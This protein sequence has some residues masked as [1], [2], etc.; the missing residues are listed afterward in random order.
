MSEILMGVFGI[1]TKSSIFMLSCL[2]EGGKNCN[3]PPR[4]E[5]GDIITLSEKR[6]RSGSSVE[7]RCQRFYAMEGQKI[8]FCNNGTWTKVPICLDPCRIPTAELERQKIEV[9]DGMDASENIFVQHGHSIELIC[10]T[11]YVL[12]ADSSQSAS[13]IHCDGTTPVIPKC[14]EIICN[15]PRI[16]N[17]SFRPKRNIY[18]V[19]D[20]IQ[21]QCYSGF[22]FEPDNRGQVVEC[23]KNGWSPPS[24]CVLVNPLIVCEEPDDIAFG[25]IVTME[26]AKYLEN[27]RVQYRCYPGYV[28]EGLEWIQCKGQQWTPRPPKCLAPCSITR[29]QLVT[30]NLFVFGSQRKSRFIQSNHSL[31]FQCSEGYVL[32][33]PSVRKCVDGYMD[34]PLCISERGKNCSDPPRIENGDIT[35]LSEKQY[36]SGSSV[37]FRCQRY[38]TIEGQNRSFCDNGTWT[39]VPI[40]L[41]PCMIPRAELE[42]QKIEVKGGMDASENIFVP[43]GHSIELTCRTGYV[44]AADSSQLACDGTPPVIPKCKEI[45]CSSPRILKGSFRPQRNIYNDGDLIRI[46]CDNGFTLEQDNGGQVAEC[47]RNGWLPSPKC[48]QVE[49]TCKVSLLHGSFVPEQQSIQINDKA[50]YICQDGYTTSKGETEVETQCLTEGWSPEPE[51]IR[52]CLKP[53][54]DNFIF[55]TTKPVFLPGDVLHYECKEEFEITKNSIS[56]TVVCTEEGW[57]PTPPRCVAFVCQAP[58]LENGA[59]DPRENVFQ[60]KMV[61]RFNCDTGFTRVGSESAQCYHFG[62][63][64]QPPV[65]KGIASVCHAPFL[66]NGAIN[67]REDVFQHKMVVRFNCDRGFIRVGSESAQCYHFGWSPQP[68]VC[69]E[70]VKSCQASPRISHGMVTDERK[71]VHQHGDLLEVQCDISFALRGSKT[72]ECVDGEWAPLPSC[73]EEVKTCGPPRKITRGIPVDAMS[74]I[75]RHGETVAYQCQQPSV[76]IGTNPAKCLHGQWELPSCLETCPPPP[77]L[78]NAI[79]IAEMRI[80]RSEEEI[81]FKCQGNFLLRGPPKIK[82]EDGKWQTPPRCLA[83][84]EPEDIDFGEIVTTEKAKYLE[85]ERVQYRCNPA[86]VLEGPEWIQCKGQKWTPHPPK[87]LAPCSITRQQ[88]ATKNLFVFGSQ[89]KALLIQSNHSR[90]FQCN[91]GYVLVAPSVRM[92]VDGYMELPL[93]ISERGRNCSG[94]PRIENGDITTLSEKR[95]RSGSS[96]EFR[97]QKDYAMEDQNRSFCDNGTWTKVPICLD[98]C[99]IPRAELESQMIELKDGIDVPENTFVQRG[100]SI[101]LTCRTGYVLAVDSSQSASIIHCDGT[102]PVIPKCKEIT[103]NSPRISNGSFL[104]QRT[105]YHD[106]DLIRIR[107]ESGFTFKPDNGE[108]VVECTKNGWSPPPK[109][110]S[111]G[112][113][114][115]AMA[116]YHAVACLKPGHVSGWPVHTCVRA[117]QVA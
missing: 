24:K 59:I 90:Q 19:G 73:I 64:P 31:Q 43:R 106:G 84:E 30:K 51:C 32:V 68:P 12:A 102:T 39:K 82:C 45:T 44:L 37:E 115:P 66:E 86:Y 80:Y 26:K 69:K 100:H 105:I 94:P 61:V 57:E 96:V 71:A 91:E 3:G 22:T 5:N 8:S 54:A 85:N 15:S 111:R 25:E 38:Y 103:C 78:P 83:C 4:I 11:G 112:S 74:S 95:Y 36:R 50:K 62:W 77:Q 104:P 58:F 7:F 52:T 49:R 109:C 65:C 107:C 34:L 99:V 13:I 41:D 46:Q 23:T 76:S 28:L 1:W 92:C 20:L 33:V 116:H 101:E 81:S 97:C 42:T 18:H 6:Y 14:K 114:P 72:I 16:S 117:A 113:Q 67:P 98:P 56:D 88:L 17:G 10:R 70:N 60:H 27:D 93:C 79:N 47:T 29:Q 110:V 9:K 108:K 63:S 55:N 48:V 87:C 89:R 75:Y 35:T 40:C 21:I 2:I 53:P